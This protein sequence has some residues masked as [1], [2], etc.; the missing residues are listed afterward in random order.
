MIVGD[1]NDKSRRGHRHPHPHHRRRCRC[2][3]RHHL[4]HHHH[5]HHQ[6]QHQ[7]QHHIP[8]P[9]LFSQSFMSWWL[10]LLCALGVV[11]LVAQL[12]IQ[13][14]GNIHL[15]GLFLAGRAFKERGAASALVIKLKTAGRFG[16]WPHDAPCMFYFCL[17]GRSSRIWY[18]LFPSDSHS[19]W[20]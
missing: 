8:Y 6:H 2:R 14:F 15:S 12:V 5:H 18:V 11:F 7:H 17:T 20:W 10:L 16:N 9:Q 19:F 3:R 4:H 13:K 1:N